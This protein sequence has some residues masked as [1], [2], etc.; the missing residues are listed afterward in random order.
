MKTLLPVALLAALVSLG[1]VAGNPEPARA[2]SDPIHTSGIFSS[3]AVGGYD[4]VA[5]FTEGRPVEGS[6][7]YEVEWNGATWSFASAANRE[8][9]LA[10]PERYAQQYGGY[11]AWAVAENKLAP[12]NP[13]YWKIV[14]GKLYLNYGTNVQKTLETDIPGFIQKA[15]ANWPEILER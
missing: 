8:A 13:E 14:D 4:P 6:R 3:L 1:A 9:F 11:C 15:E 12:G 7:E 5:Y 10:D 2:A